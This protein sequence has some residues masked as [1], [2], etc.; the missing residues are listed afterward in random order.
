MKEE[1]FFRM[2][3]KELEVNKIT[4]NNSPHILVA[5]DYF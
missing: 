5:K 4:Q 1:S 3:E 2:I